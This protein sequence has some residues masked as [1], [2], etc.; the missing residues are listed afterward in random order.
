M[1]YQYKKNNWNEY[2]KDKSYADNL[3][4]DAVISKK[5]L[6]H[7]EDGIFMASADLTIGS[8]KVGNKTE[9]HIEFN[10][11]TGTK[12]INIVIDKNS[13]SDITPTIEKII[14]DKKNGEIV[15]GSAITNTDNIIPIEINI[16]EENN[17]EGEEDV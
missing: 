2:D 7:M 16:I 3:E 10:R 11:I 8:I 13:L 15:G 14:L 6:D 12:R 9:A 17:T 1:A 5:K 4:N